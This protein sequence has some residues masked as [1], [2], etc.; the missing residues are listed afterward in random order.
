MNGASAL[1]TGLR[2]APLSAA[3]V[4]A[5]AAGSLRL[6]R[7]EPARRQAVLRAAST[8]LD[9]LRR[10]HLGTLLSSAVVLEP[11]VTRS[12]T[13]GA[14][15]LVAGELTLGTR[16]VLALFAAGHTL[17]S[18][19]V[20]GLLGVGALPGVSP[21]RVRAEVDVGLSY[22]VLAVA[23]ALAATRRRPVLATLAVAALVVPPVVRTPSPTT[24][25]HV[26]STLIGGMGGRM[27]TDRAV[28]SRLL[29]RSFGE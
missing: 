28:R 10:G 19:A 5:V 7:L 3:Y 1:T 4:V 2:R 21:P 25:G 24:W 17:A 6:S 9:N 26:L 20:G 14:A 22:G 8:N 15:V 12:L 23:A 18:L 11:P 29:R 27:L 13:T 16:P